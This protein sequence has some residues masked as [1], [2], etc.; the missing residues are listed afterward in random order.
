[1]N[2]KSL[3]VLLA[4]LAG[5]SCLSASVVIDETEFQTDTLIQKQIG[6]GV[7]YTRIRIPEYPL[8]INTIKVDLNNPYNRIETTV[9]QDVLGSTESLVSA[10]ARQS[11]DGH[12][13]LAGANAN[14]WCTVEKPFAD[15]MRGFTFGANMKNGKIL[16]ETNMYATQWDGGAARTGIVSIDTDKKLWI[17]SMSWKG[18]V[19]SSKWANPIEF[20]EANKTCYENSIVMYNSY[21]GTNR[22]FNTTNANTEVFLMLKEGETWG[23][24][25]D[26]VAVVKEIKKDSGANKLGSY[27]LC[28]SGT[29]SYKAEL[30]KLTVGDEVTL[31]YAWTSFATGATP[32][33]EQVV[34]GNAIVLKDGAVTERNFD[35][36]YN[37]RVYSRTG[38]GMS[39][40]GKTLF[41]YVIDM[42]T[43]PVYGRSKG[44]S[45]SVMAQI[46][47]QSGVWNL[48]TMDAGGSAQMF[49]QDRIVNKTTEA[50]PRAVANGWMIYSVAKEDKEVAKLEFADYKLQAPVYSSFSPV[51]YAYDKYGNLIDEDF[52]NATLTCDSN[53]GTCEGN[54]FNAGGKAAEGNL[55]ATYNGV[56]VSRKISVMSAEMKIRIKDIHI[57]NV[58][59]Y[60]VEVV[61]EIN[62]IV[63][64]YNPAKL[65]WTVGDNTVADIDENGVLTGLKDGK[66]T[67]GCVLNE[68]QDYAGVSVEIAPA[69]SVS[70]NISDWTFT[71]AAVVSGSV[72]IGNDGKITFNYKG[73]RGPSIKI[74]KDVQFYSLPDRIVFDITS[75]LPFNN[76]KAD[77][78]TALDG[79]VTYRYLTENG[80]AA[81]ENI[82]LVL[83]TKDLG[84]DDLAIFPISLHNITFSVASSAV[85]GENSLTV[86]NISAEYD[87]FSGIED[88]MADKTTAVKIYPNPVADG[89]MRVLCSGEGTAEVSVYDLS[90]LV[91]LQK[92]VNAESPATV[93]VSGLTKGF[94]LVKVTG[95]KFNEINTILI[96]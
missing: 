24:N 89:I 17:E 34:A 1:M 84:G 63:Y 32:N 9:G 61:A 68:F 91:V 12:K 77:L 43:D 79:K 42:S 28:L 58:R 59:R 78:R 49:V 92:T 87:N 94:Y 65:K 96:K 45:T 6:P 56:S 7:V 19:K 46:A 16:T 55:T 76:V 51:I 57:D 14:F 2:K 40:D 85:K 88:V 67:I 54:V 53:I 18:F 33:L 30:E 90:G 52:K 95:K 83:N 5:A 15:Y 25:K 93:D 48:C 74:G 47:K 8:N 13:A 38:Y 60:P 50:K 3:A 39:K 44:C 75:T 31:N 86:N 23:S 72:V 71:S 41:V 11:A 35:E 82:K 21:Y 27:D 80:T 26:F 36:G 62:G 64:N 10:A 29:G 81:G 37:S 22:A 69:A 73:G 70:E 20:H 4:V 66:T